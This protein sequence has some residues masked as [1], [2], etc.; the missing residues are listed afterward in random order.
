MQSI[1]SCLHQWRIDYDKTLTILFLTATTPILIKRFQET[2]RKHPLGNSIDINDAIEQEKQ[3]LEPLNICADT[4]INTDQ[5]T[6]HELRAFVQNVLTPTLKSRMMVTLMS[7][8]FKYNT[9]P[10]STL[11]FDLR[12]LPNPYFIQELQALDG[13][14]PAIRNYLFSRD[15]TKLYWKKL[16]EFFT[17]NLERSYGEGRYFMH[18]A[19]GC[20]GGRHR[21]V[22]FVE[23]LA[24]LPLEYVQFF[25][26]H[27]DIH[28]EMAGK[29]YEGSN[30]T[31]YSVHTRG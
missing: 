11:V 12:S 3:F 6:L 15:E 8:G 19:L 28:K 14:D 25:I 18:V 23:E 21:S 30:E 4:I 7:F 16:V 29:S 20:T 22:A 27:R 5:L 13:R 17:F 24:Q 9:P 10:E 26:K 31:L 1:V 2:R